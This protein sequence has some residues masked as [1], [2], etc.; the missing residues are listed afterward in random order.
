MPAPEEIARTHQQRQRGIILSLIAAILGLWRRLDRERLA[1]SWRA[2]I[3]PSIVDMMA[4]AQVQVAV[5]APVYL[6]EL[7]A[8]QGVAM[9]DLELVPERLSGVTSTGGPLETALYQPIIAFKKLLSDGVPPDEAM[10]RATAAITMIAATQAADAGRAAIQVGMT[11]T[12]EWVSYV[13]AVTLP[14]CSRCIVLAGRVYSYSTGFQRHPNCDCSMIPFREGDAVPP[15]PG[16]LFEQ[17]SPEEQDRRFGKAG[18]ESL[19]LGADINQVVAARRGMKSVGGQLV[20]TEGMTR[21]G[22]ANRRMRKGAVRLMPEQ[23]L[24]DAAGDRDAAIRALRENG[25]LLQR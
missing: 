17:M 6:R 10:R 1:E 22:A 12:K 11:A 20:T 18:A 15:S 24:A 2:G 23:I 13:R 7:A 25:Y 8:A 5:S 19:R 14:A 21:R 9:S 3:G 4:R 16:A